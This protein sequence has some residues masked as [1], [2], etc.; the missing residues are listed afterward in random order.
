MV[1]KN[2]Q[3]ILFPHPICDRVEFYYNA[4]GRAGWL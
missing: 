1:L 2:I 4:A 3:M